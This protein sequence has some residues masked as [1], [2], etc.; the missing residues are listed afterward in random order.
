MPHFGDQKFFARE[1][2]RLGVG[3]FFDYHAGQKNF[4]EQCVFWSE[5]KKALKKANKVAGLL[6]KENG[7]SVAVSELEKLV[8]NYRNLKTY[9]FKYILGLKM[10]AQAGIEPATKD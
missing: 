4:L 9:N 10:V 6:E 8:K 7:S 3:I 2:R 5:V 1:V